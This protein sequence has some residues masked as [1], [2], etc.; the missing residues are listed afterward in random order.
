[1][2][3]YFTMQRLTV[4][5]FHYTYTVHTVGQLHSTATMLL[6]SEQ[7]VTGNNFKDFTEFCICIYY[8]TPL[9]A[10][11]AAATLPGVQQN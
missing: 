10:A 11:K 9:A 2:Q 3:T 8:G 5:I 4:F 6:Y 1:M 7:K